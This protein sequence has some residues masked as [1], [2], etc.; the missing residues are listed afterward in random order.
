MWH[1]SRLS[2]QLVEETAIEDARHQ[3][4]MLHSVSNVYSS[5]IVDRVKQADPPSVEVRHDYLN[6]KGAI[7]NPATMTIV[8]G[9]AISAD[10]ASG[11]Q[12]KL[13]SPYPFAGRSGGLGAEGGFGAQAWS[14]LGEHPDQ[15][16][17]RFE[18]HDR[19]RVLRYATPQIMKQSCV[20]CHN[21]HPDSPK[22]DW[23]VG[24]VR[25]VLEIVRPLDED[26]A[27]TQESMRSSFLLIMGLLAGLLAIAVGA[28]FLA[29]RRRAAL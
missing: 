25:G 20:N 9:E 18:D 11:V 3:T 26:V 22:T 4:E 21:S 15:A 16:F 12:V 19:R 24:D 28:L 27:R 14:F 29:K 6:K 17:Y 23:K 5:V 13:Y 7:P 2:T 1:F 10:S 8:L